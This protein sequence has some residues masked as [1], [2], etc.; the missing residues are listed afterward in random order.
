M[1]NP[2]ASDPGSDPSDGL[3]AELLAALVRHGQLR[4]LPKGSIVVTEGEPALSMYLV[5]EGQLRV[6]VS[7]EAGHEVV[8]NKL[9]PGEY[10]GE[11]MLTGKTRSASVQTLGRARLCMITRDEFQQL[12]AARPDLAFHIIQT[13]IQRVRSLSRRVQGLVSLDVYQRV[14]LLLNERAQLREGRL[15][16]PGPLSQQKVADLVDASRSMIN[17]IFKELVEGG[18]IVIG[19]DV[20][21]LRQPLPKHW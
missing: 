7:D 13:L 18:Y 14:V 9:G 8:L 20:I 3:P 6:Y 11:S 21:E 4:V 17:R 16:V 10:F 5:L 12:L 19:P 2:L 15:S 1:T